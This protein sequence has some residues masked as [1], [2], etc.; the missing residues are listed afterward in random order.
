MISQGKNAVIVEHLDT[1]N[2]MPAYAS[3][4]IS[5][6]EDIS[7][8]TEADEVSLADVLK[9]IMEKEDNKEIPNPKKISNNELKAYFQEIIPDYDKD[10]VYVSDMKKVLVWY[11]DLL[12]HGLLEKEPEPADDDEAEA[13]ADKNDEVQDSQKEEQPKEE[14]E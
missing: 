13:S 12:K 8:Y 2:R 9:V 14:K 6:L 3:A 5:G 7:I 4:R 10:R 11:N 1:G